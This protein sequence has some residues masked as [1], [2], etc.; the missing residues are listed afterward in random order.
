MAGVKRIPDHQVLAN[1]LQSWAEQYELGD[2]PY[3][4]GLSAAVANRKNLPMWASLNPLEYLPHAKVRSNP[5]L[6]LFTLIMTIARNALV[7]LPVALTWYAI[8]K[9]TNAFAVYT[10]NN[11]LQ[12]VNFLDFWENGY[13][14]LSKKWS[15]SAVATLDFLIIL[16]IIFLTISITLVEKRTKRLRAMEISELDED[17]VRLAISISTY[18]F[19]QQKVTNVSMNQSLA[20]A[21]RDILNSTESLDRTSKE[22]NKTVKAIPTN[23]E[24]LTEIKK[25]RPSALFRDFD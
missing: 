17:R 10:A 13:G 8:S 5:Q 12:V 25:N 4:S 7:F 15:L 19:S 24:L 23:R 16:L 2:D 3:V 18:L 14:V 6:H 11:T 9:A 1:S 22:L 20:K 21:L